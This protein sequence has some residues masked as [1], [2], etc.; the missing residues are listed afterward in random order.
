MDRRSSAMIGGV[1]REGRKTGSSERGPGEW[2]Y[3]K[4]SPAAECCR[5]GI[6]H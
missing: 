3:P 6:F 2:A 1:T 4:S 5:G